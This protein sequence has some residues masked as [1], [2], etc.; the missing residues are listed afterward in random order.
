MNRCMMVGWVMDGW[1]VG[2]MYRWMMDGWRDGG[3]S[4]DIITSSGR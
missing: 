3:D 4:E 1:L 2:W